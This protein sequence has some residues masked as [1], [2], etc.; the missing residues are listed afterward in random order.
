ML[1][2]ILEE[3]SRGRSLS[4]TD[5]ARTI[6]VS[7]GLLAQMLQ[8]LAQKGYLEPVSAACTTNGCSACPL[9]RACTT[10]DPPTIWLLTEKGRAAAHRQ[11][12]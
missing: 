10:Q 4:Q 3:L 12:G 8:D 5:L 2:Q 11:C 6:G 9:A 1:K 7:D